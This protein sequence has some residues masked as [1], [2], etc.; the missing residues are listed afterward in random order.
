[1]P[2]LD[3]G[4]CKLKKTPEQFWK[5]KTARGRRLRC[6]DCEK[7]IRGTVE[8]KE[9][10]A[11]AQAE[12][13][14]REKAKDKAAFR[15]RERRYNLRRYGLTVDQYD[16]LAA[17]QNGLCAICR[18]PPENGVGKKLHVDHDHATGVVRGLL[19]HGCNTGLGGFDEDASVLM[20]AARYLGGDQTNSHGI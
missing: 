18:K 16:A 10:S 14:E 5:A 6:I 11:K 19:C 4:T 20:K 12:Y 17:A 1:M 13:R 2:L 15:E 7:K 3:C 8:Y 9:Y